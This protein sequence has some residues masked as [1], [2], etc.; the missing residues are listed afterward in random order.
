MAAVFPW[1]EDG[2][3]LGPATAG[4]YA[5]SHSTGRELPLEQPSPQRCHNL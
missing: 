3:S 1:L 4:P 5:G 2:A